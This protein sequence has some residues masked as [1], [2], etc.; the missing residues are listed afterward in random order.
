MPNTHDIAFDPAAVSLT[1]D[2]AEA[3]L[4]EAKALSISEHLYAILM[5][6]IIRLGD[7]ALLST[8]DYKPAKSRATA[9]AQSPSFEERQRASACER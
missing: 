2:I 3:T 7:V 6:S 9:A 4:N 1:A 5:T 8:L